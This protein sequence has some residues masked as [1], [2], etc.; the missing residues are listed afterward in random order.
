M[1]T[2]KTKVRN[3]RKNE[4]CTIQIDLRERDRAESTRHSLK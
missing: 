1:R 3:T 2:D 4:K